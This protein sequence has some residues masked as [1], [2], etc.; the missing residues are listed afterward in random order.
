MEGPQ[1]TN[2][3][4]IHKW[5]VRQYLAGYATKT[6]ETLMDM[7]SEVPVKTQ[8]VVREANRCNQRFRVL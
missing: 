6:Q 5:T 1:V 8:T 7:S 2:F 3:R 4:F